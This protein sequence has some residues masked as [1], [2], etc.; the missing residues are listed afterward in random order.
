MV[1]LDTKEQEGDSNGRE[2]RASVLSQAAC[3]PFL[4]SPLATR[5]HEEHYK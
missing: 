5:L 1:A 4:D 3:V 2:N